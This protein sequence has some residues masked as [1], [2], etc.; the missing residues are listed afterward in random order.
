MMLPKL[1]RDRALF[2]IAIAIIYIALCAISM[3]ARAKNAS[4]NVQLAEQTER[5]RISSERV[6]LLTQLEQQRQTCYQ[7]LAVNL[8]L[9]EVR[10]QHN[11]KMRDL[12]RQE[13]A[14]S[15]VQRKRQASDRLRTVD[16]RH[17]P[18]AL[19]NLAEQRGR[20]MEAS[21]RREEE[22]AQRERSREAKLAQANAPAVAAS[23]IGS[24]APPAAAQERK[25]L[26]AK[27][28]QNSCW[29]TF[30]RCCQEGAQPP[31][32]S[33][34]GECGSRATR[35]IGTARSQSQKAS[36]NILTCASILRYQAPIKSLRRLE[37]ER[38]KTSVPSSLKTS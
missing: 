9:N 36:G 15:D 10:D 13:V 31:T 33:R 6:A 1:T 30:R 18:Q 25:T 11:E 12:K 22:R 27:K 19:Q 35:Q 17:S 20:A 7:K 34:A 24:A 16:D 5:Q 32:G 23:G 38:K 28:S 14:L 4:E 2:H 8:C 26:A 37:G 29:R 3:K 21:A